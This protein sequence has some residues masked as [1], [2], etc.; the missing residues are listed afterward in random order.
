MIFLPY[1]SFVHILSSDFTPATDKTDEETHSQKFDRD[2]EILLFL[3]RDI[4]AFAIFN[5]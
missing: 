5:M 4:F 1:P 2:E 3:K